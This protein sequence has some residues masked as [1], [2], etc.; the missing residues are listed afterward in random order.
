VARWSGRSLEVVAWS[1]V[2]L[3]AAAAT[4]S[5]ANLPGYRGNS[6]MLAVESGLLVVSLAFAA[7]SGWLLAGLRRITRADL[8]LVETVERRLAF[9]DRWCGA[10]L[11]AGA[12]TPWLLSLAI[13]TRIDNQAGTYRIDHPVEFA[14]VTAAMLGI[15]YF[16]LKTSLT[17]SVRAMRAVLQDVRAQ[18]LD[19][20]AEIAGVR[21]RTRVLMAVVTAL[22]VLGVLAGIVLW[23]RAG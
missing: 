17:P 15:T 11:V 10:W 1:Y 12:V 9:Y 19:A 23:L 8:P 2:A 13:T 5:T 14:V 7:F 18:A 20:T 3:L 21:R 22:L 16:A 6:T 4:L